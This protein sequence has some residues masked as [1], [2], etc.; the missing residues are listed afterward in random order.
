MLRRFFSIKIKNKIDQKIILSFGAQG[1]EREKINMKEKYHM[2]T[3]RKC[4]A[5][6]KDVEE[7]MGCG[8]TTARAIVRKM[9]K[10]MEAMGKWTVPGKIPWSYLRDRIGIDLRPPYE[11]VAE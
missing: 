1:I 11:G 4:Y 3:C 2:E 6:A 9:N 5:T 8:S 7:I 10:E